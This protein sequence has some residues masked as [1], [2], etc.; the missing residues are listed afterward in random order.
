MRKPHLIAFEITRTCTLSCRHCRG[1][2]HNVAYDS[3]LKFGEITRI[4]DNVASF[5]SPIIILTGGE[6]LT[7]TDVYDIASYSS[8]LGLRTVLATCGHTL[9]DSTVTML[10]RSGIM[11][12]SVSI[13]GATHRTHDDFRGMAGAFDA[14]M[15]GLEAA[16]RHSLPFQINSTLTTLN[17]DE[18]DEI[19]KLAV[20]LG[21]VA[22]HPFLLVPMGRGTGLSEYALPPEEY[23]RALNHI[24]DIAESSSIS[25]KP[26][27]SPHYSRVVRQRQKNTGNSVAH[28]G[29]AVMS[30]GCLGGHGFAFISHTGIVQLCGFLDLEA[31]NLR[32]EKYNFH[33][34][35]DNSPL[36]NSVRNR[37]E[38]QGKCGACEYWHVCGGCRA[39]AH[40]LNGNYL[41]EEPN[42]IYVPQGMPHE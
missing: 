29:R 30:R 15:R 39:R 13:D 8:R 33:H 1:D 40:Y 35:W 22:F 3:E 21:A 19:H 6:P 38:Y 17:I 23:E 26:T 18:L 24:A 4:L 37:T 32:Q 9:D 25:I 28:P 27:C 31:G 2:S 41:A 7:R 20:D 12:I 42:C 36:F 11:R 10:Q 34:I 16:K 5:S 14:T